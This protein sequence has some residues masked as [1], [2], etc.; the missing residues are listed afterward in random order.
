MLC[1]CFLYLRLSSLSSS[2]SRPCLASF[3]F[4]LVVSCETPPGP[5]A[6]ASARPDAPQQMT[7][8]ELVLR[9]CL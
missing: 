6:R 1:V 2:R 7:Q 8:H 9:A 5:H 4:F 3:S